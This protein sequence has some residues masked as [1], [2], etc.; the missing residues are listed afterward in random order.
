MDRGSSDD[1]EA[2]LDTANTS[3][4][5]ADIESTTGAPEQAT[6]K[7][8]DTVGSRFV[9]DE[10]LRDEV[11]GSVY[12]AVDQK[13][14]KKI[15]ILMLD[16]AFARDRES[17]ER[18][19]AGVKSA[20]ELSHK[21]IVGTFGMG[22]EGRRRYVAREYVDGQTLAELLEKKATA[23]KHFT[24]KGAYNLVAHVCNGLQYARGLMQHGCL[25]P[26]VILINRTGRVKVSEFG[27][28]D[29]RSGIEARRDRLSR[30]DRACFPD[31][32]ADAP[33]AD[34]IYAVGVLLY[35]LLAGQPP[36]E[37][38]P[39]L[40]DDVAARLPEGIVSVLHRCVCADPDQRFADPNELKTELLQEVESAS[41]ALPKLPSNVLSMGKSE[42]AAA[43][44]IEV[45]EETPAPLPSNRP[46]PRRAKRKRPQEG[47][48]FVIPE[49]HPQG[50]VSDD[51]TK[52]RWLVESD[53]VDYGPFTRNA[54]VEK[55]RSE[56]IDAETVLYDIETDRRL[57]LSEFTAFDEALMAW[58]HERA[59]LEKKRAE[60][61]ALDAAR[62]RNR[63]LLMAFGAVLLVVGGGLGGW[64]LY[65]SMLPKPVRAHLGSL[66]APMRTG[67]PAVPLP[68][69]DLPETAAEK[70]D[71]L[72]A[73][74]AARSRKA[75]AADRRRAMEEARLAASN[76]IR[77][78][79]GK[80]FDR[81]AF[82]TAVQGRFG[83]LTGCIQKEA[84][85]NPRSK[86]LDVKITVLP[87]GRLINVHMPTGTEKANRCVRGALGGLRVPPFDGSNH[88]V[89]LPFSIN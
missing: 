8:G 4:A 13:S 78:G 54:V 5:E 87:D 72:T 59:E 43:A 82:D 86:K 41:G 83:K 2:P 17:T 58:S 30:W 80:K 55:L 16:P 50:Q 32:G 1:A 40:P 67:L 19:R 77:G 81:A 37:P 68:E 48:G 29:L 74:R 44:S 46:A 14:G 35:S 22:K 64:F 75:I 26:S 52:E 47:G 21:N 79:T 9:V 71:R 15:A 6:L 70:R 34:D 62:R 69:D 3:A 45:M 85:R 49:L 76:E 27:L 28:A 20:T 51:G 31:P 36:S 66:V 7:Q 11:T 12:R 63:L 23:G 61:A 24:L 42:A 73:Q 84:V 89:T 57:A 88:S 18:V 53:G 39:T 10:R 60:Q 33:Q 65:Q 38:V 56:E 25:R